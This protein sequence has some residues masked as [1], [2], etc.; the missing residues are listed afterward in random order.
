MTRKGA[1]RPPCRH[2][3]KTQN[4]ELELVPMLITRYA[5]I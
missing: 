5:Y 2:V 1:I 3:I 4:P